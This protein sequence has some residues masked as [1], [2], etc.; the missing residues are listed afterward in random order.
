[1][2]TLC[3]CEAKI[4]LVCGANH[5][6]FA[7][8]NLEQELPKELI[9]RVRY[10]PI[11]TDIG[12]INREGTLLVDTGKLTEIC[13]DFL[14]KVP[15]LAKTE[16]EW[17]K[18]EAVSAVLCDMPI[19][20]MDACDMAGV[21]FLY[22][23]N[24]TWT[25]LY[26][27]FLPEHIWKEYAKRYGKIQHTMLYALNNEEMLEFLQNSEKTPTS[28]VAR[29]IHNDEVQRIKSQHEKPPVFVAL[30]MSARFKQPI[31]VSH[32]PYDFITTLGV[33]LVGENVTVISNSTPN[34]QDY[35]AAADYV[36]TK[37]GWGTVAECILAQR[38]MALF[39]RDTVLED[40]TTICKLQ[41]LGLAISVTPENLHRVERVIED[42]KQL[43]TSNFDTFYDAASEIADKLISLMQ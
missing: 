11:N 26:R 27:E 39:A 17:L 36:I 31:D 35:I 24:F 32:A 40:R 1:M 25:E 13:E 23:G 38:P 19:W 37:A 6:D 14:A 30:G 9:D 2:A 4:T 22:V 42:L 29:P 12:L 16:A 34:T 15:S 43:D 3:R 41:K 7:K 5:L 28:V 21:P 10:R 33:P 18:R 20:A 8:R